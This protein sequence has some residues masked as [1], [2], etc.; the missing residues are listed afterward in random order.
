M[1]YL[2][3][4]DTRYPTEAEL[5]RASQEYAARFQGQEPF[6]YVAIDGLFNESLLQGLV[7]HFPVPGKSE[8]YHY[9]NPLEKKF[10]YDRLEKLPSPIA[11]FLLFLNSSR[12]LSFME[13]LTGIDGL[14][15]DPYFRGGGIHRI[16]PGGKLDVH[17]D[18]NIHPKLKLERRLN[19]IVYLNKDWEES[20]GG[21]LDLWEGELRE[22][23]HHLLEQAA[24]ILPVFNRTAVFATS[25]RSYH[26]HPDP[27]T[28]PPDRSRQ[29]IAVYYYTLP[30]QRQTEF[31]SATFVAR[32]TDQ[33]SEEVAAFRKLRSRG[34]QGAKE[35]GPNS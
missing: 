30:Q 34:R 5:G 27:L 13:Q 18:F 35:V 20:Y 22:G 9:D 33:D 10:A 14:I 21:H 26:G 19:A 25:D 31:R 15:P 32:P 6:P 2:Q 8:F 28:C 1:S 4:L 3:E 12:F 29:S 17:L 16:E 11:D 7:D 23:E 24:H